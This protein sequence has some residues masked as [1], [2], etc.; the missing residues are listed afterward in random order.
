MKKNL[1]FVNCIVIAMLIVSCNKD[2]VVSAKH[3]AT[4]QKLFLQMKVMMENDQIKMDSLAYELV[5]ASHKNQ[6][7]VEPI[8]MR[9]PSDEQF[10]EAVDGLMETMLADM[11]GDTT[12][13][14]KHRIPE[15]MVDGMIAISVLSAEARFY[16]DR[17]KS[18]AA[19][20]L[21]EYDFQ[22]L[23]FYWSYLSEGLLSEE[24]FNKKAEEF[25]KV[26]NNLSLI[27]ISEP[28]RPY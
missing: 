1:L 12:A 8:R 21:E 11:A 23:Q 5:L 19:E 26:Y 18:S 6:L 14:K 3:D 24:E 27:H 4:T 28:T 16:A 10:M 22:R 9:L 20:D 15:Q 2:K 13:M 25:I 7:G 17:I